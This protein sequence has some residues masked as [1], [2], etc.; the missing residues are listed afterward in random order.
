MT[1]RVTDEEILNTVEVFDPFEVMGPDGPTDEYL[2]MAIG[3]EASG[4]PCAIVAWFDLPEPIIALCGLEHDRRSPT[5]KQI[6]NV[7]RSLEPWT[8]SSD[9]EEEVPHGAVH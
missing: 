3:L 4:A 1:R 2:E 7:F 5:D 9:A 6:I 8:R